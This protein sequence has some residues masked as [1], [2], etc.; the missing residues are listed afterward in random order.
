MDGYITVLHVFALFVMS[1]VM[2][3]ADK[4]WEKFFRVSIV[5][6]MLQG[7]YALLQVMHILA[8]SSQSGGRVDTTFG[9]A[10]YVAV[11]VLFNIFL[12]LYLLVRDRKSVGLQVFYGIALVF[13]VIALFYSQTRG[14]LLGVVGG[15]GVAG[16]YIL[17]FWLQKKNFL[18]IRNRMVGQY[19]GPRS[20]YCSSELLSS[21]VPWWDRCIACAIRHSCKTAR[22]SI[23]SPRS[24]LP[25]AQQSRASRCGRT[26]RSPARWRSRSSAGARRTSISSSTN[27]TCRA[28][29]TR[30]SGSTAR[31]MS[32]S[33]G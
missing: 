25:S 18:N 12:T 4:W 20:R 10:I 17:F 26:W 24:R 3:T 27:I 13:Q 7:F 5:A 2:F 23:A 29:T 33:I 19:V 6:S 21:S 9:N 22:P 28:C 14:A 15:L 16:L 31:T 1:A 30:S 8:I 32:F 11:F